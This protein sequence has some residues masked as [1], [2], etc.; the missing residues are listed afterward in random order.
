MMNMTLYA[1]NANKMLFLMNLVYVK[2]VFQI[3]KYVLQEAHAKNVMKIIIGNLTNTIYQTK[4][5][6]F[7]SVQEVVLNV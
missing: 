3:V 2:N 4:N 1:K 5:K 7:P 6:I